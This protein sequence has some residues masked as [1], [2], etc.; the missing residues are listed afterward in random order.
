[1]RSCSSTRSLDHGFKG[2]GPNSIDTLEF[3]SEITLAVKRIA[4]D[5]MIQKG[6]ADIR[7]SVEE[8]TC[9]LTMQD[10]KEM[11]GDCLNCRIL[12]CVHH[13]SR[14]GLG[15]MRG[16]RGKI[17]Y[18]SNI[19]TVKWHAILNVSALVK[20]PPFSLPLQCCGESERRRKEN[21]KGN[22]TRARSTI[23]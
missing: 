23:T 11:H 14:V 21:Q 18:H 10:P 9:N 22:P 16:S 8:S 17:A 2:I 1:M 4:I 7:S 15:I 3:V 12:L 5:S 20:F 19:V 13:G 6:I